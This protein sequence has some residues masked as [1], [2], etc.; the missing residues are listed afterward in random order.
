MAKRGMFSVSN[1]MKEREANSN[2]ASLFLNQLEKTIVELEE[3]RKPSTYYA[4]SSLHCVRQMYF[5]RK[6]FPEEEEIKDPSFIGICESG[7]DRHERIQK[8]L[9]KMKELG[10][11]FEYYDVETYVKEHGLK[12]I[13]IKSKRGMETHCINTR[14]N[15]SFMTDGI[16]KYLPTGEFFVFEFKTEVS[17]KF[18]FRDDNDIMHEPQGC[19]YALSFNIDNVIYLYEDR[20]FCN[21]K[22]FIFKADKALTKLLVTD[23]IDRCEYYLEKNEVPPKVTDI[24]V[25]RN[26]KES[27]HKPG[28]TRP[29]DK[30]CRYCKYRK[31]CSKWL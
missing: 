22:P 23:K 24:E 5:K 4:P 6:G 12:D 13:E 2:I 31:E 7:T 8:A 17:Q 10:Y 9:L 16:L 19:C 28:T 21:K 25:D 15:L 3:D 26:F 27:T 18:N 29:V 14:Y 1:L 11:D 30:V 20:N